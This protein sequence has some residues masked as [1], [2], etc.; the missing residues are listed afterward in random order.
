MF[1]RQV[2]QP[3]LER[4]GTS[5]HPPTA[6]R[7]D[8]GDRQMLLPGMGEYV[9][10]RLEMPPAGAEAFKALLTRIEAAQFYSVS[11]RT[12][13]RW[14]KDGII[15]PE[16]KVVIGGSVRYRTDVLLRSIDRGN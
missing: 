2:D 14:M 7:S 1:K 5:P 16:A 4:D 12:I 11:S 3:R 6:V 8:G 13:D 10:V 15:P 9:Q